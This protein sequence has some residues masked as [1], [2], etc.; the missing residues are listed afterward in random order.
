MYYLTPSSTKFASV[1]ELN[2]NLGG[3]SLYSRSKLADIL[4][5]QEMARRLDSGELGPKH[6]NET[7][8][9]YVN[10][11]HPGGVKTAA[12]QQAIDTYG[13][14][15]FLIMA[16]VRPFFSDP[17]TTGCRSALYAAT[18]PEVCNGKG[19]HGAYIAPDK[20]V[21]KPMLGKEPREMGKRLWDLSLGILKEKVG[22]EA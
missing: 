11:V 8:A 1:E 4:G 20:K 22:H 19:V 15:G 17:V 2:Q 13:W 9:I 18:S 21:V 14:V 6:G 10:V 3:N 16:V 5:C 12:Q 7:R